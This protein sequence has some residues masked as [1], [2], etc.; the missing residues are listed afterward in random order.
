[1]DGAAIPGAAEK[2]LVIILNLTAGLFP[3]CEAVRLRPR[4]CDSAPLADDLA[5]CG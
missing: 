5:L 1:M 4:L 2:I 3:V